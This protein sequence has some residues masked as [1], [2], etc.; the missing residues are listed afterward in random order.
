MGWGDTFGM[1]DDSGE[2]EDEKRRRLEREAQMA[3]LD[4]PAEE[5]PEDNMEDVADLMMSEDDRVD[6]DLPVV[7]SPQFIGT[8][9]PR[10]AEMLR[11][12]EDW[13]ARRPKR[14]D[15]EPSTKRSILASLAGLAGG[16]ADPKLGGEITTGILEGPR[17]RANREWAEEGKALGEVSAYAQN[18]SET[19][20]KREG[21]LLTHESAQDRVE[22]QRSAL[23]QRKEAEDL[24]HR[25]RMAILKDDTASDGARRQETARH[26]K[27]VEKIAVESNRIRSIEAAARTTSTN[28]YKSRVDVLNKGQDKAYPS[29]YRQAV[30]DSLGEMMTE[31]P[32]AAKWFTRN[33]KN[34]NQ[35]V[36]RAG[37]QLSPPDAARF[38]AFL[39]DAKAR[40]KKNMGMDEEVDPYNPLRED[41]P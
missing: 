23:T 11:L 13:M 39:E 17:N 3:V 29:H 10:T 40:A 1:L 36:P 14:E 30:M 20:R 41:I 25:D 24:R 4:M 32:D 9:D 16:L 8:D 31:Y 27:E 18:V 7:E 33:P 5:F 6:H 35:V 22:V 28:A 12:Q 37:L 34:P 21:S 2:T 38:R 15:Y 26:N 19:R